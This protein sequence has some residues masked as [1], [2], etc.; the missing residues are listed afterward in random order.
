MQV[1]TVSLQSIKRPG[2]QPRHQLKGRQPTDVALAEVRRLIGRPP[3]PNGGSEG[4]HRRDLLIEHLH[5]VND[6]H[7]GLPEALLV[8]LA[9]EMNIPVAEVYEVASFYHHF[10]V[11]R[12]GE[13]GPDLTVRVCDGLSCQLA[14]ASPLLAD[15]QQR[16][17]SFAGPL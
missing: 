10:E 17:P 16:L 15:L 9:A 11:L 13:A 7:H 12:D 5:T 3:A 14:G 1:A 8:A 6:A 4:G 2:Q